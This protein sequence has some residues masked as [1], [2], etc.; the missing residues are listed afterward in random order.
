VISAEVTGD[1]GVQVDVADNGPGIPVDSWERVFEKFSR[2]SEATLA[3]SAGLGLPISREIMRAMGGD[4]K[5]VPSPA[6][7]RFRLTLPRG[8]VVPRSAR[9]AAE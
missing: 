1:G 2:L 9:R 8:S 4:L 5:L 7:A 6:G 3:G